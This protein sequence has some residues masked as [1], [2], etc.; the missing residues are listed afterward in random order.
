MPFSINPQEFIMKNCFAALALA[1][2]VAP[3]EPPPERPSYT[4]SVL[5]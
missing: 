4:L 3:C 1:A 5:A 2:V